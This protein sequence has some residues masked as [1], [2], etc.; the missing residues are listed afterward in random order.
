MKEPWLD[1]DIQLIYESDYEETFIIS[2]TNRSTME[3]FIESLKG[4]GYSEHLNDGK[5]VFSSFNDNNCPSIYWIVEDNRIYSGN[6][7]C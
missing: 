4:F 1:N 5:R 6:S 7:Q 3:K 2:F